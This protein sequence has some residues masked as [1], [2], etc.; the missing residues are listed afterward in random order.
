MF[1]RDGERARQFW[2]RRHWDTG[3]SVRATG[4]FWDS[5]MLHVPPLSPIG[6]SSWVVTARWFVSGP[7]CPTWLEPLVRRTGRTAACAL[8]G[9]REGAWAS[10]QWPGGHGHICSVPNP[11]RGHALLTTVIVSERGHRLRGTHVSPVPQDLGL[12]PWV[13]RT[14]QKGLWS[15]SC[16]VN[17]EGRR[18]DGTAHQ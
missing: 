15:S 14:Y 8:T 13:P 4:W 11:L 5:K 12:S 3:L 10:R 1:E 9:V 6:P 2:N 17:A 18:E 16:S 7:V